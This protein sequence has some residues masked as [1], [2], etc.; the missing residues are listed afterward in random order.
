MVGS[1]VEVGLEGDGRIGRK[2]GNADG[3]GL[4]DEDGIG[5]DGYRLRGR[6][7]RTDRAKEQQSGEAGIHASLL[8]Y[9]GSTDI[10]PVLRVP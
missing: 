3:G 5:G 9:A 7:G 4:V 10:M 6:V 1:I 8:Q 2:A